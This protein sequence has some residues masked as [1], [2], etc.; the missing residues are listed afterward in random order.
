MSDI[1]RMVWVDN[2]ASMFHGQ[3][4]KVLQISGEWVR[5]E[6]SSVRGGKI[7]VWFM[8]AELRYDHFVDTK[9]RSRAM[10]A[11]EDW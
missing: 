11:M 5:L 10:F 2:P 8:G 7:D 6:M 4:A 9:R 3:S 1:G